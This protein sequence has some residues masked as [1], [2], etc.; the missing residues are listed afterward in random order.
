MKLRSWSSPSPTPFHPGAPHAPILPRSQCPLTCS[1]FG[2]SKMET[3]FSF[4]MVFLEVASAPPCTCRISVP[5]SKKHG[6]LEMVRL[7]LHKRS[8]EPQIMSPKNTRISNGNFQ[9]SKEISNGQTWGEHPTSQLSAARGRPFVYGPGRQLQGVA[10]GPVLKLAQVPTNSMRMWS[11]A[12]M[13]ETTPPFPLHRHPTANSDAEHLLEP[14]LAPSCSMRSVG[15]RN[16]SVWSSYCRR[17][18]RLRLWV[19]V[20]SQSMCGLNG[21]IKHDF[22]RIRTVRSCDGRLAAWRD[23]ADTAG[24]Q[25]KQVMSDCN[26]RGSNLGTQARDL[27]RLALPSPIFPL[28]CVYAR[29]RGPSHLI[30]PRGPFCFFFLSLPLPHAKSDQLL[31]SCCCCCPYPCVSAGLEKTP[32]SQQPTPSTFFYHDRTRTRQTTRE[33]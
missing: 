3:L 9:R 30:F 26:V 1:E 5:A 12:N 18:S 10:V 19:R 7:T 14:P 13:V 24:T 31:L 28:C 27:L 6:G 16:G 32:P 25:G 4:R 29:G 8:I 20:P 33:T 15:W 23:S 2:P 17:V 11:S 21:I 22:C